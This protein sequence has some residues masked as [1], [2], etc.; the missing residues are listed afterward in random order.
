MTIAE[1]LLLEDCPDCPLVRAAVAGSGRALECSCG[2]IYRE[3]H[4]SPPPPRALRR[5][6]GDPSA[7][8]GSTSPPKRASRPAVVSRTELPAE[9]DLAR[10]AVVVC[11]VADW[12][13]WAA[14]EAEVARAGAAGGSWSNLPGV[15]A[16]LELGVIGH[17]CWGSKGVLVGNPSPA[18]EAA[19]V[20]GDWGP[21]YNGLRPADL[22]RVVDLVLD[23]G[24]GWQLLP[25]F[26]GGKC[27]EPLALEAE[28][29]GVERAR[30]CSLPQRVGFRWAERYDADL[31]KRWAQHVALRDQ[32]A[33]LAGAQ[34]RG[35]QL[36]YDAAQAWW[37]APAVADAAS[38]ERPP[39]DAA[40]PA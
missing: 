29:R 37:A 12:L 13:A 31:F 16:A 7:A 38:A 4:P 34:D 15:L 30:G 25:V 40:Q 10:T 35:A 24:A 27:L 6:P 14:A 23:D 3:K 21:R 17:G 36:L 2:A 28:V 5:A 22:R 26:V 19:S 8:R 11:A 1:D 32:G 18:R 20:R 39:G 33:A 9:I